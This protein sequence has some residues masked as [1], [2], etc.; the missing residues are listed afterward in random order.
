MKIEEFLD[1]DEENDNR[2]VEIID[3]EEIEYDKL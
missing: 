1:Y 2:E 3:I